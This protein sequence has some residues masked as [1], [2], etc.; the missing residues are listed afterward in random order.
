MKRRAMKLAAVLVAAL[1]L[2]G[3]VKQLTPEEKAAQL[4]QTAAETVL[5]MEEA[6]S[7]TPCTMGQT[8]MQTE[9]T[10]SGA[11]AGAMDLIVD[12]A[13]TTTLSRDPLSGYTHGT[14]G[15]TVDG[16]LVQTETESYMM[17]EDGA[18]VCYSQINGVWMR[19]AAPVTLEDLPQ[20]NSKVWLNK[21]SLTMDETVSV[22]DGKPAICLTSI[23]AGTDMEP[24]ATQLL[25][26]LPVSMDGA[27]LSAVSCEARVY[28]DPQ[29]YLPL[30]EEMKVLGLGEAATS[31]LRQTGVT[32]DVP[33]CSV[34]LIFSSFAPQ[35]AVPLPEEA[36]ERSDSWDRLLEGLNNR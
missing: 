23:L 5:T 12:I 36:K 27:D 10:L 25:E 16:Q 2:S 20:S 19:S 24:L 9:M 1:T 31:V 17:V 6:L 29:T 15:L 32:V 33:N 34:T 21:E 11:D 30:G 18:I 3:C 35:A 7:K 22:W 26:N 13:Y 28:L 8:R 4:R 14:A